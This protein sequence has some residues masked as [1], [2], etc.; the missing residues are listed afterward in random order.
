M[1]QIFNQH[2]SFINLKNVIMK[3][4]LIPMMV[5]AAVSFTSCG[6]STE[7][8][9]TAEVAEEANEQKFEDNKMEKDREFL[10]EAASGGLMEVELG[11]L[12]AANAASPE[13]KKFGAQMVTDHT[14]A[15]EELKALAASKN[16]TIPAAP[17][18]DHMKHINDLREKKGADFDKAYM[19]LMVD[20]HQED[21]NKYEEQGNNGNDAEI[22]AFAAGKVATLK[23]HHE[24]SKTLNDKLK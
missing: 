10:V 18:E 8:T 22:K 12:A 2:Q 7:K 13:V 11:K 14:K 9:D 17:G 23:K 4:F 15:N 21:V 24:M 1:A 20:D 3:K 16:V 5:L 19:S 6:D